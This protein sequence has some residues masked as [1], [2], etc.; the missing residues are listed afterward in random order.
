MI[1]P[2]HILV[3]GHTVVLYSKNGKDWFS[4][5]ADCV[6]FHRRRA[7]ERENLRRHF[8][9]VTPDEDTDPAPAIAK[10]DPP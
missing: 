10:K 8:L 4:R 3:S 1:R 5:P 9:D 2:R 6:G 7:S